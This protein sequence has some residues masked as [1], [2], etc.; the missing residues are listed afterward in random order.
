VYIVGILADI[1]HYLV[2]DLFG[3]V[4]LAY[5][6]VGIILISAV[7][8]SSKRVFPAAVRARRESRGPARGEASS[9]AAGAVAGALSAVL[10][11]WC[12]ITGNNVLAAA[13][14]SI[15]KSA[16]D[17]PPTWALTLAVCGILYAS[18]G[19]LLTEKKKGQDPPY[20]RADSA[21][22]LALGSFGCFLSFLV[23]TQPLAFLVSPTTLNRG[24]FVGITCATVTYVAACWSD[25]LIV[26][27]E[28]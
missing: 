6:V 3:S 26:S 22:M 25:H 23:T 4:P 8:L 28:R 20:K 19:N 10:V 7:H 27:G 12:L 2:I 24:L 13:Y 15:P 17:E 16:G 18:L 9:I 21:F 11:T 5:F 1:I 14:P